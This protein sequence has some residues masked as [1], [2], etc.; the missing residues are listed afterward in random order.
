MDTQADTRIFDQLESEVRSYCRMWPAVFTKA[1]GHTLTAEDGREYLDFFAGAGAL[2]YGHNNPKLK[3]QLVEYIQKDGVTHSLDMMTEAKREFLQTLDDVVLSPRGLD[4]K[5]MLPGPTGTNAVEAALKLARLVTGRTNVLAFTNAFHGMTLGSL[6]VTG[7]GSKRAGAGVP[8]SNVT[9]MP[10][11]RYLGETDTIDLLEQHLDDSSSGV[12]KPAALILETVQAEGGINIATNPWLRR[13]QNLLKRHEI[14]LIVDDIQVGCGRTGKFF[15]FEA[16]N[17]DP[18]IVCL[19]KSLSGYGVP[20]SVTMFRRELDVWEPG[21]HNGTFRGHNLAFVTATAALNEYWRDDELTKAVGRKSSTVQ[22]TLHS[23]ADEYGAQVRG[24]GMINGIEFET[25]EVAPLISQAAF[26]RGLLVETA[27]ANDQVV[28]LIPPL[29]I[30]EDEL[31]RGL[32][33]LEECVHDAHREVAVA[34]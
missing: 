34:S 2:N 8:L 21:K 13:L 14:L 23:L 5:V 9:R 25:P 10:F 28:K 12:D 29:T 4:Y 1:Q 24:R 27:G 20:L 17:L 18:D 30:D 15:S 3:E 16:A 26:E 6:A 33:L 19:S 32:G 22:E 11:H 7:N 31:A